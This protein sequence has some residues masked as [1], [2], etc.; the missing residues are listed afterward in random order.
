[1]SHYP[2]QYG[3][4]A[5]YKKTL[6]NPTNSPDTEPEMT[7]PATQQIKLS[8]M[9]GLWFPIMTNL[10]NLAM[11]TQNAD[12]KVL[13]MEALFQV[14][15]HGIKAFD[16]NFWREILSQVVFPMLEDID[17]AIQTPVRKNDEAGVQ[18]YLQT[19]Q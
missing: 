4:S 13:S 1:M 15:E 16:L 12:N 9:K 6:A 8:V 7:T 3:I 5:N 18:F 2:P 11:D 10:T 19:I 17:L 14:F